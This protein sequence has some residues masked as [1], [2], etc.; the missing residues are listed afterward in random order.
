M[1]IISV[2][3]YIHVYGIYHIY[4]YGIDP[5]PLKSWVPLGFRSGIKCHNSSLYLE[6]EKNQKLVLPLVAYIY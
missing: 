5:D 4:I 2:I 3:I 1:V 6:L